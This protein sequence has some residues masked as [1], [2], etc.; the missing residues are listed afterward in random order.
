ML[1]APLSTPRHAALAFALAVAVQQTAWAQTSPSAVQLDAVNVHAQQGTSRSALGGYGELSLR[2]TPASITSIELPQLRDRQ[3]RTLSELLRADASAGD[4]YAP[5]GYYEN[6]SLRG[7]ALNAANGYRINGLSAVGE[8]LVAL[9]N[10]QRVQVLKGLSGLQSGVNEP[11]GLIDY[12]TKRPERVR[13]LELGIDSEGQQRIAAD[14]GDWFGAQRSVGLR[15]NAAHEELR[16]YVDHTD[17]ERDFA[18]IAADWQISARQLLQLDAEYQ[19]RHQR[20]VAGYALLGGTRVP[21]IARIDRERLL[22]YQPWSRPVEMNSL[23]TQLRWQLHLTDD[24]QLELAASRSQVRIDD[25]TVFAWGCYGE[26]SCADDAIPNYFSDEGGY[27]LYDYRNPDDTRRHDQGRALLSGRFATGALE[28]HVGLGAETLRRTVERYDS[29]NEYIGN[30]SIDADPAVFDPT[31]VPLGPY[32][33]RLDSRQQALLFS[34]RIVIGPAWQLMLGAR[35]VWLDERAFDDAGQLV[36]HT[37]KDVVLPQAA[38]LFKPTNDWSLYASWSR[39]LAAGGTAPW[40]A[41]NAD[42]ILAPT[43]STQRE[44]GARW[45]NEGLR[46][47]A[48]LFDIAQAYQ[49]PQPQDD[50]TLLYLQQGQL[51][52]RGIELSADGALTSRLHVY[53]SAAAIRSRAQDSG[54]AAYEGHQAINVPKL[55]A[56]VQADYSVPGLDGLAVLG[57]VQ[58]SGERHADRVGVA[59]VGSYTLANL[60]AR[61]TTRIGATSTTWRLYVDNLFDRRYWRDAGEYLGDA[62]LFV[63]AP[64]TARFTVQV[65]F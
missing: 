19:R 61:Y 48:T 62:Y 8:Q 20:S 14:W 42:E 32:H 2:D 59:T 63:G 64:R 47:G 39:S 3:L 12:I 17:G 54:Y 35:Q 13:T 38:L 15:I 23:N 50:G 10:K 44:L 1:H 9:D 6:V 33:R 60:G 49:Y 16:S 29:V 24:W 46:V 26:A 58:Y 53:A 65:D 51:R 41:A 7:Y 30:G 37:R 31:T 11:G 40:F 52:N 36:R 28:H 21:D 5:I 34:D 25:F 56:S 43:R 55:R 18:S 57:G 27:D 4:A 22:G 45:E